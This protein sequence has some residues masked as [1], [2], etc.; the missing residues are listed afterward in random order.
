MKNEQTNNIK[1]QNSLYLERSGNHAK[2]MVEILLAKPES[3]LD[4][5]DK[6][7]A[8]EFENSIADFELPGGKSI[9]EALAST[10]GVDQLVPN[11]F[12]KYLVERHV[13]VVGIE[14]PDFQDENEAYEWLCQEAHDDDN[15][16]QLRELSKTTN[17]LFVNQIA[18]TLID[19]TKSL[20]EV[21]GIVAQPV[22]VDQAALLEQS[23]LMDESRNVLLA[24]RK[25][26]SPDEA[27]L[28]GAKRAVVDIYLA[29]VNSEVAKN[30]PMLEI[31][32]RQAEHAGD[33]IT[34]AK[35]ANL[36]PAV[37]L[38]EEVK[39]SLFQKLDYLRNGMSHDEN[40]AATAVD[41]RLEIVTTANMREK[42]E[43]AWL[44]ETQVEKLKEYTVQPQEALLAIR[45]IIDRAG[46]LSATEP[47]ETANARAGRA[48][49]GLYQVIINP[50]KST[51]AVD[52]IRG[53]YKV[54]ST[55][56]SLYK[57][58]VTA[59]AHELEHINQSEADRE[60]GSY[61]RIA[62]LK[63]KRVSML[64]EAGANQSERQFEMRM[65]GS[66]K[67]FAMTYA[68]ALEVLE[69]GGTFTESVRAFYDEKR[70][71][72]PAINPRDAAKEAA[73]RVFRL[74]RM[75]GYNSQPIAYAEEALLNDDLKD[76]PPHA[77]ARATAISG[78]DLVDQVK[79]H[80]YGLLPNTI[81]QR[82]EWTDIIM[83]ELG[84]MI[85]TVLQIK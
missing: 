25:E 71:V 33:A 8:I 47:D 56:C 58:I 23:Q 31:L 54:A 50:G 63:G 75:G 7:A 9:A 60:L 13:A 34:M 66:C 37:A 2:A 53:L 74:T 12:P 19:E 61:L 64:R 67:P 85:Q 5:S 26:F 30:I 24:L 1:E 45:N 62:G 32:H 18:D 83:E 69:D 4:S 44:N 73:D 78:L 84:P 28:D 36:L 14:Y 65:S 10:R 27:G 72:F 35:T 39:N 79:L 49:D 52:G 82:V 20:D 81:N 6:I 70:H 43:T 17:A 29:R 21:E 41:P 3:E 40:G 38:R 76:A 46:L 15:A 57:L 22:S 16:P 42:S 11:I 77:R 48:N 80:K 68:R 51:F 55:D 59:G